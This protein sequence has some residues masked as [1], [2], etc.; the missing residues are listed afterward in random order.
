ML[1]QIINHLRKQDRQYKYGRKIE[2]R[3]HNHCYRGKE[4]NRS[5]I[6]YQIMHYLLD[7]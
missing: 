5:E 6:F 3:L 1:A 2:A 4:I 7:I